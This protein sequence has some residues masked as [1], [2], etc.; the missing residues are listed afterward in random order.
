MKPVL[1]LSV[2]SIALPAFCDVVTATPDHYTLRHEAVSDL[3]P[4]AVWDRLIE[5][6]AWWQPDHTWSGRA[7]NLSLEPRAGGLW[8]ERWDG[9]EV[10]HGRVLT[11]LE[12]K[13][14]RLDAPF[15]P[16]QGMG[17][18]VTWT[19]TLEPDEETGGTKII[20]DEVANGSGQSRLDEVAPAV[21]GVK[22]EAIARLA[23]SETS[24]NT[25]TPD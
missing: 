1:C 22:S 17:V 20:F 14:L 6:S 15:G 3:E 21:D 9:N 18:M 12:D 4:N 10:L 24:M 8:A 2:L 7:E 19:I 23:A 16:L 5:P 11:V 13:M 25:K